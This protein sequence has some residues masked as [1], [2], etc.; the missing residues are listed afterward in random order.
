MDQLL[1]QYP[2]QYLDQLGLGEDGDES[3]CLG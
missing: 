2:D 1:D 3:E